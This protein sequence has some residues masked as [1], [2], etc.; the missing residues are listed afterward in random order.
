MASIYVKEKKKLKGIRGML[1]AVTVINIVLTIVMSIVSSFYDNSSAV[2][3]RALVVG[4]GAYV[5]PIVIYAV[6]NGITAKAASEKFCLKGTNAYFYL[7][8]ALLGFGCQFVQI[9]VNLPF[10]R[11]EV[12]GG[13]A[14]FVPVTPWELGI[15]LLVIALMPA[16]FEEFLFRGIVYC[17]MAELNKKAAFIFSAVMFGIMHASVA[18]FLGYLIMGLVAAYLVSEAKSLFTAMIFHF[19]N[20]GTALFL[21]YFNDALW[22][23]PETMITLFVFGIAA[24]AFGLAILIFVNKPKSK[25]KATDKYNKANNKEKNTDTEKINKTN[26]ISCAA[27]LGQSFI[28]LPVILC[29]VFTVAAA[30]LIKII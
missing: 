10:S 2:Y 20:N 11:F 16:I 23:S 30:I 1:L 27:L 22:Y 3:A 14:S 7:I 6:R 29:I 5:I 9:G 21:S 8:A 24:F 4:L 25:S 13:A 28:S 17:S 12:S 19:V 15:S 26:K 18:A